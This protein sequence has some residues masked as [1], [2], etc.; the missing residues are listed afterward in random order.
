MLYD[1]RNISSFIKKNTKNS[2][3]PRAAFCVA[4]GLSV[5]SSS[6]IGEQS[7]KKI[8]EKRRF[9]RWTQRERTN[10]LNGPTG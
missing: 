6:S 10:D 3:T 9:N 7:V 1:W 8:D 4:L 5:G 2:R